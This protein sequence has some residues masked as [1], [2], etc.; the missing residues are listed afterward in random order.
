MQFKLD[1]TIVNTSISYK[2][3]LVSFISRTFEFFSYY[4]KIF[5]FPLI[6]Q[7]LLSWNK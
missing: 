3:D 7:C 1:D 4:V 5:A 6:F 2:N